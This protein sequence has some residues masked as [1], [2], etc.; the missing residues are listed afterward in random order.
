MFRITLADVPNSRDLR[1]VFLN[2][3]YRESTNALAIHAFS[4]LLSIMSVL[5]QTRKDIIK[6]HL[7]PFHSG[8]SANGEGHLS[9][10][11][12]VKNFGFCSEQ[13]IKQIA[14]RLFHTLRKKDWKGNA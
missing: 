13:R 7:R 1:Y 2:V 4:R 5:N 8:N 10:D 6:P 3:E 11:Y 12:Y 14:Q 9:S